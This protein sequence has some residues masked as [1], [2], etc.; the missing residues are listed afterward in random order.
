[1]STRTR[2]PS[3]PILIA[4]AGF[5]SQSTQHAKVLER[6]LDGQLPFRRAGRGSTEVSGSRFAGKGIDEV[7]WIV[8]VGGAVCLN[9]ESA[10][11]LHLLQFLR[12][13]IGAMPAVAGDAMLLA[14]AGHKVR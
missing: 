8:S 2:R 7:V 6:L 4:D 12:R 9:P 1:M 3:R 14:Q 13:G 5:T 11:Q 10:K